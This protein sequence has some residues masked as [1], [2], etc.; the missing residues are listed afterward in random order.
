MESQSLNL[1]SRYL[2][3]GHSSRI[4]V[5]GVQK[6]DSSFPKAALTT[7]GKKM[8]SPVFLYGFLRFMAA[9]YL[10]DKRCPHRLQNK[11]QGTMLAPTQG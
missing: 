11:P 2:Q 8:C 7:W 5:H 1:Q 9:G 6:G 3:S 4:T 10:S